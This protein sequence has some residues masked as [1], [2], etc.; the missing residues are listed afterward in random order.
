MQNMS[1]PQGAPQGQN[2]TLPIV[3]LVLGILS[4]CCYI[5]PITGLAAFITGYMGRNNAANNPQM[6]GGSGLA[7]AGMIVGGIF[8]LLG[9]GFYIYIIAVVGLVA[10]GTIK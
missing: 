5:A 8:F 1:Q 6:Y 9:I 10:S 7:L 3:S 4:L 2:Q